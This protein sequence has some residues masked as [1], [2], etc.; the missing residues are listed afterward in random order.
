MVEINSHSLFSKWFSESG[1]LVLRM[2]D[3]IDE[4]AE[5]GRCMVFVLIDEVESLGMSRDAST[6]R[7]DPADSIRAVNAL[8]TQIDRIRRRTNVIVLC[9][10]NMEG[11]LDRA[12]MDRADLV[13]HVGQPSANA[14]YSILSKCVEELIRVGPIMI[15]I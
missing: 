5:D 13:R 7:G 11:C 15:F 3:Q 10:S 6:S 9:T 12:L 1:K 2:F 8:L 4:L 14:V